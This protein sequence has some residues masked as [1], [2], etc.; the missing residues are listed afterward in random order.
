[1]SNHEGYEKFLEVFISK[2][3]F[4]NLVSQHGGGE[5]RELATRAARL[6]K[7]L[8]AYLKLVARFI[9]PVVKQCS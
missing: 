7:I 9:L 1:M 2:T 6:A 5:K 4:S 8:P 3:S